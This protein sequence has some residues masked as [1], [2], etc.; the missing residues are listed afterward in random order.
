M[1]CTELCILFVIYH[2]YLLIKDLPLAV[3]NTFLVVSVWLT[4]PLTFPQVI[5]PG[6]SQRVL[7]A[8]DHADQ[9]TV[10]PLDHL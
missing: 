6:I 1:G 3:A 8:S 7:H 10:A 9:I 4:L 5:H 2:D